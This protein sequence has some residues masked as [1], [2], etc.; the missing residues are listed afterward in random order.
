MAVYDDDNIKKSKLARQLILSSA[1]PLCYSPVPAQGSLHLLL[2]SKRCTR[3][4]SAHSG[5]STTD[6]AMAV[7]IDRK[8]S[9]HRDSSDDNG[10]AADFSLSLHDKDWGPIAWRLICP[11]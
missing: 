11:S 8:S 3:M 6:D 4:A 1:G 5:E 9:V 2:E 10:E 7:E